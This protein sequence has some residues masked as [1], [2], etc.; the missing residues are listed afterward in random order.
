MPSVSGVSLPHTL[1]D[2]GIYLQAPA[3]GRREQR[4][5][6]ARPPRGGAWK[7]DLSPSHK[8][9]PKADF[10]QNLQARTPPDKTPAF[11]L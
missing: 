4:T 6:P 2:L 9:E 11:S 5:P 1:T 10:P 3:S 7:W 8:N